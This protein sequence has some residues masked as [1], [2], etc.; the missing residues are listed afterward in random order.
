MNISYGFTSFCKHVTFTCTIIYQLYTLLLWTYKSLHLC[1][2]NSYLYL[3]S[4][5]EPLKTAPKPAAPAGSGK[6][7]RNLKLAGHVGFDILPDQLVNK[8]V[9]Q[10]FCF[11]VLCAGQ[12]W[13]DFLAN[14]ECTVWSIRILSK[15][16]WFYIWMYWTA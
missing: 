5:Q 1:S 7:S 12:L 4:S 9:G 6:Q 8:S 10:G 13:I 15:T 11:N 14:V 2:C 16:V 3:C